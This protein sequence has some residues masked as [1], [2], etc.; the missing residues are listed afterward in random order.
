MNPPREMEEGP[1]NS[2]PGCSFRFSEFFKSAQANGVVELFCSV[3]NSHET[4]SI[5]KGIESVDVNAEEEIVLYNSLFSPLPA[6]DSLIKRNQNLEMQCFDNSVSL[7]DEEEEEAEEK[8]T[9]KVHKLYQRRQRRVNKMQEKQKKQVNI[10]GDVKKKD[11][12]K[13]RAI[14]KFFKIF[15]T[16]KKCISGVR[17]DHYSNKTFEAL[18]NCSAE[19]LER[20]SNVLKDMLQTIMKMPRKSKDEV[21]FRM[22][23]FMIIP[24]FLISREKI[25]R[26]VAD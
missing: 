5:W 25:R 2:S 10:L 11:F 23:E 7:D 24:R 14:L 21:D 3:E 26:F 12:N 1:F 19:I 16:A 6:A 15:F 8:E 18:K 4:E 13:Y 17:N 20:A 9:Q 22:V